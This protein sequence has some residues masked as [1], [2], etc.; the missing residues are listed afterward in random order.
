MKADAIPLLE[1]FAS[2]QRLEVPLFQRQ[3]IWDKERQWEPLWED[4]S[5]K[6]AEYLEGRRDS[7]VHFLG[8]MVLDQKFT[9]SGHVVKR[10]V[11]D[12]QQRLTTL[13]IFLATFRDFCFAQ[14]AEELGK[15]CISFTLNS[16]M[17]EDR[18]TEIYKVWPTQADRDQFVS[19]MS[20]QSKAEIE[21]RHPLVRQKWARKD[22]P[23][24][25][26][27]EAY[28]YFYDE[29]ADF[30]LSLDALMSDVPIADR[31]NESFQA[32]K[33]ALQ[34]V[35]VDLEQGDDAQVI[36]E[37][38]NARGEPLLP[39][40]L[41]RNYIFLRAGRLGE[42]QEQLYEKYWKVF[43]DG[44]W[45]EELRQGRLSRP[46]SDLYL[47]HFLAGHQGTEVPIKHLYVEYKYWIDKKHPFPSVHEE[48]RTL[49]KQAEDYRRLLS[50]RKTDPLRNLGT[51][52]ITFE[53]STAYP[54]L[55]WLLDHDISPIDWVSISTTIESY[56]LRR[57]V[58][59][60][61]TKNYTRIFLGLLRS[62]QKE[63]TTSPTAIAAYL[64][65]LKGESM[66]W[67]TDDN[68]RYNWSNRHV[69]QTMQNPK[70][71]YVLR[72]LNETYMSSLN[73]AIE[74][75]GPLSVEHIMP[76]SWIA[77]WPLEDGQS[78]MNY[79]SLMLGDPGDPRRE[80]TEARN[81]AIQTFGNLTILTQ[82]LNSALSNSNWVTKKPALL[83][84]SLLPI[85]QSLYSVENWNERA[86]AL[87]LEDLFTRALTIWPR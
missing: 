79:S 37:T 40:D 52:L 5:R 27:V 13:Q 7:P 25:R 78:G 1:L 12:G 2:K 77:N 39:A 70:V 60:L 82:P 30:F 50:P 73:E 59:N 6:F 61:T 44:F 51:F 66:E 74:F 31:L 4:I 53:M 33:N 10:Q 46:R 57:A 9:P 42:S 24:P 38:L 32:L 72:R 87:R 83:Q 62:I 48:L 65:D 49:A 85:N 18:Q 22:D 15:E 64:K 56:I 16:G 17:M 84:A 81:R 43:E 41:L 75:S 58:C 21:K 80:P 54:L 19:V 8:A 34:V 45:R 63:Q 69:Y 3:Y 36:F 55:L 68:F 71:V 26:M 76:Q 86:I 20:A 67:P 29:I 14:G 28:L 11:I 35:V 47:Q 23:R